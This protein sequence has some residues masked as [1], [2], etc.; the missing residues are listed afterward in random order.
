MK[1]FFP[2]FLLLF[3]GFGG[4]S[5]TWSDDVAEIFYSKCTA[6]HNSQGIAPFELM[7]YSAVSA[8]S[9]AIA[10]VVANGYMPPWTADNDYQSYA[11][12]RELSE[13]EK[14]TILDW[15]ENGT[16]EGDPNNAPPAPVY[17]N[18][19]FI[20][21]EADL[22]LTMDQYT[23]NASATQ[24][25]YVCISLPTGLTEDKVIR[26]FEVVPGNPEILHHCLVY[27]DPTGT[28]PT[29]FS[30]TCV[31]PN[32][33][34]GLIGGYTPGAVPTVFPSNGTDLNMGITLPAGS[35]LVLAM[36]Y[37]HGS[38][39]EVDQST[40]RVFFYDDEVDVREVNTFPVLQNWNFALA[41][42]QVTEVD[43]SFGGFATDVSV[44]SVF[45]HMHLLGKNILAY[46]E[47]PDNEEIP[48]IRINHWDFEWQE[49]FFFDQIQRVPAGSTLHAEGSFDNS[50]DNSHN[51]NDPPI[52]VYPGLNT[53]DEM[54][55]VYFHFLPYVEG[56]EDLD[57]EELTTLTTSVEDFEDETAEILSVFPNP[58]TDE[59]QFEFDL[60]Y[61]STV[62]LYVYDSQ[63]QLVEKILDRA[64][65]STGKNPVRWNHEEIPAGIYHYSLMIN[66]AASS[67]RLAIK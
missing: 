57:I 36:H 20:Q 65:V 16:P 5:Q 55:L 9:S 30:G 38:A 43:A 23:S 33:D 11:H 1:K 67:G 4:Q 28:Y 27:I 32:N 17:V 39:G 41:P 10:G 12:S 42:N 7:D 21:L 24:D 35:N 60:T 61:T 13:Q 48:F 50:E 26:A 47:T 52:W 2:L 59:V 45:P 37:P 56:D 3:I 53:S 58:S 34:E 31:G 54:F 19:G 49:F 64:T 66:G 8:Y 29:D 15:I 14:T 25:D 40:I 62:S 51:P 18:E 44:L 63:G 22:E 46:A 6:C